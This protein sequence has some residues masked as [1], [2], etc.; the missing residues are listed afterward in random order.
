MIMTKELAMIIL[1][2]VLQNPSQ[3]IYTNQQIIAA[4]KVAGSIVNV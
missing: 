3:K 1:N 2:F 4:I